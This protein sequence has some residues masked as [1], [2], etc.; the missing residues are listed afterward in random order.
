MPTIVATPG[1]ADANSYATLAEANAYFETRVALDPAWVTTGDPPTAALIMAARVL[2]SFAVAR[3]VLRF[4]GRGGPN[5][6][7]Y[8]VT[9]RAWTGAI[10][11]DTQALAWPRSGMFDRLGRAIATNVVP[12][13]LKEAQSELAGQLLIGD[14]TL[15]NDAAVEGIREVKAGSVQVKFAEMIEHR[16]LPEAVMALLVPSWLTDE[17]VTPAV[18][19]EFRAL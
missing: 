18:S 9:S 3:K 2:D 16:V 12:Q 13:Q 17:I 15:D 11:T 7:P 6:R 4:D 5:G 14:R 8:Y 1:A 10:V 19:I